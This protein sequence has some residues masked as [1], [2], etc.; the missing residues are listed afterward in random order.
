MKKIAASIVFAIACASAWGQTTVSG[1]VTDAETGRPVSDAYIR[2]D[3]SLA[4]GVTN[5]EGQFRI[6]NLPDKKHKL[7]I[8]H[9]SYA[10]ISVSASTSDE[11]KL[12][13]TPSAQNIGQVVV[14]G[15]GTR[16]GA[17][18]HG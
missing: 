6:T 16:A 5:S 2:V 13:M 1:V 4:K 17:G 11:L 10:P 12:T 9:V 18:Y 7:S 15:T 8:T 3:N 14:T